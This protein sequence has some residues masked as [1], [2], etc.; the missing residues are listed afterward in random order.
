MKKA[1][2]ITLHT[3]SNYGS[4][5]QTYATQCLFEKLGWKAEIIDYYRSDNLPEYAVEKAF[6]GRRMRQFQILWDKAPFLKRLASIPMKMIVDRQRRPFEDFRKEYLNLTERMYRSVE[7]LELFPPEADLYCTGSDQVWNSVWNNGFEAPYFLTFAPKGKPCISFAASVGREQ[8]DAWERE[9]MCQ[10]LKRY[11]HISMRET[12]GVKIIN[13][14]GFPHAQLV[15]DPTLMLSRAEW[16]EIAAMPKGVRSPYILVYQLNKNDRMADYAIEV[17]RTLD[18][19]IVK[20]SYGVYDILAGAQTLIAPSVR[21]FVGLFL[22]AKYVITDSFHATAYALN[23]GKQFVAVSPERF[24]TRIKSI[25]EITGTESHM[26]LDYGNV[27]LINV[28][29]DFDYVNASLSKYRSMSM[30]YLRQA[31]KS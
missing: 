26:L 2:I 1:S 9:P 22:N 16:Q 20:I 29:I 23:F 19:P 31:L 17:G 15:L 28:P 14:L 3:V 8:I 10:A 11:S 21:E 4:C 5:L 30:D 6:N 13:D 25:M 7:E 18:I 12:S 27:D 24:S